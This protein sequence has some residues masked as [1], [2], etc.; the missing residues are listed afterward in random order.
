MRP[1]ADTGKQFFKRVCV[2]AFTCM[3]IYALESIL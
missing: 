2:N 1:Y 3:Y